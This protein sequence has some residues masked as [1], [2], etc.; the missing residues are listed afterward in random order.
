MLKILI[1]GDVNSSHIIKWASSIAKEGNI[2]ALAT[3]STPKSDWFST[4]N[5]QV[6]NLLGHDVARHKPWFAKGKY[7]FA[8]PNLNAAIKFFQPQVLHAHY[9]SSYGLLGAISGFHPFVLSVWGADVYDFPNNFLS[10]QI[11]K[12][13]L[14]KADA[15]LSTSEVM[16]KQTEKFT[17]KEITVTPFGIDTDLFCPGQIA[18]DYIYVGTVKTLE[19]KY[20]IKYLIQAFAQVQ[21][22]MP[23]L[24]L[25]LLIV[26]GGS[27]LEYLKGLCVELGIGEKVAF[28]G[29]VDP[30]KVP[31]YHQL[32]DISVFPSIL[33]SESFGVAVLE[34][35]ACEKPVIVSNVGGLPEVVVNNETGIVVAPKNADAL[36]QAIEKLVSDH[37]LRKIMG[38]KGRRRV[39]KH[40]FWPNN[41]AQMLEIYQKVS[42]I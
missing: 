13:N 33:D 39:L 2:V 12:F 36:A 23:F 19:E 8:W 29:F 16:K 26:G 17:N 9:A 1:L 24:P 15:I 11:L 34:A 10:K 18:K 22:K 42:K 25:R 14:K 20:G 27:Q 6:F 7:L 32:L 21:I 4:L 37:E 35:S 28:T 38:E 41:V 31:H 30:T 40:Y 3:L 5:I